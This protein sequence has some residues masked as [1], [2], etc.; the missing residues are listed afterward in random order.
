MTL[1]LKLGAALIVLTSLAA[2]D[3]PAPIPEGALAE[4]LSNS[5]L[6]LRENAPDV[7]PDEVLVLDLAPTGRGVM[8]LD[9]VILT[10]D[11]SVPQDNVFCIDNLRLAGILSD[12]DALDCAVVE[13]NGNRISLEW[14]EDSPEGRRSA[15][16]TISPL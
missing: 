1:N 8:S 7:D 9:P 16:G 11:W 14:P 10:F 5:R 3:V 13:I 15:R 12:D 2:C 4:Q 6:T